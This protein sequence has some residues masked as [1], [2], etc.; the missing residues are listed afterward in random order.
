MKEKIREKLRIFKENGVDLRKLSYPLTLHPQGVFSSPVEL[1]LKL[2]ELS[3]EELRALVPVLKTCQIF[4]VREGEID[5]YVWSPVEGEVKTR[6]ELQALFKRFKKEVKRLYSR[7][8]SKVRA[9][10]KAKGKPR[11]RPFIIRED[12]I[13]VRMEFGGE[14]LSYS[15]FLHYDEDMIRKKAHLLISD[16]RTI[17]EHR[18]LPF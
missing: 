11:L 14:N 8:P 9:K 6:K 18:F 3:D 10:I 16:L 15:L 17:A 12:M 4:G 13:R 1:A 2:V 7:L 5:I